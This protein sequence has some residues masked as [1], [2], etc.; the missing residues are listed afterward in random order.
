ML[1]SNTDSIN[2]DCKGFTTKQ[3]SGF[4]F[5]VLSV[6]FVGVYLFIFVCL[7]AHMILIVKGLICFN[8]ERMRG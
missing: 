5:G 3:F 6:V 1:V 2:F 8:L 7:F 4:V